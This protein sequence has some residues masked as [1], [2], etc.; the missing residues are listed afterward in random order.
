MFFIGLCACSFIDYFLG[1]AVKRDLSFHT[2]ECLKL[3]LG[4]ATL[5]N[6]SIPTVL[7]FKNQGILKHTTNLLLKGLKA[8]IS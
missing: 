5:L 2:K 7:I 4:C 3:V 8:T 6:F 1:S